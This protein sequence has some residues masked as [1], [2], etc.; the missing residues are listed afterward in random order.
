MVKLTLNDR[1][2]LLEIGFEAY[3]QKHGIKGRASGPIQA[4]YNRLKK[5][6]EEGMSFQQANSPITSASDAPAPPKPVVSEVRGN[7]RNPPPSP[8]PSSPTP[9][10]PGG[11]VIK[12]APALDKAPMPPRPLPCRYCGRL[13]GN[14]GGRATHERL[15][16]IQSLH[17]A[18]QALILELPKP[19]QA[20]SVARRSALESYFSKM[21]DLLAV[22][23]QRSQ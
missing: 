5:Q 9:P 10:E 7:S 14:E 11:A 13:F 8:A 12:Q 6:R 18:V 22:A 4:L 17:P 3:C 16:G 23:G 2:E 20:L 21:L 19:G 1:K 15:C